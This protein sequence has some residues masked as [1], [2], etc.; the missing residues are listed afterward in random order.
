MLVADTWLH[1][2]ELA[3][4]RAYLVRLAAS[5]VV[6]KPVPPVSLAT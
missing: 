4:D 1:L 6:P 5:I 3:V 2:D